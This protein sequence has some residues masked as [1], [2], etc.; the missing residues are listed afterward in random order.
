MKNE[1]RL[2]AYER[3]LA[4][5][6]PVR[7]AGARGLR[8]ELKLEL[9][10]E[11]GCSRDDQQLRLYPEHDSRHGRADDRVDQRGRST[12]QRHLR[13]RTRVPLL[14][15]VEDG[16][17]LLGQGEPGG[18]DPLLLLDPPVDEGNDRRLP[19]TARPR[20]HPLNGP[21]HR[22][23]LRPVPFAPLVVSAGFAS[24]APARPSRPRR[25][26]GASTATL[27]AVC[28]PIEP[29]TGSSRLGDGS[30][31]RAVV[32]LLVAGSGSPSNTNRPSTRRW[33]VRACEGRR[34]DL[35]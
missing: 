2:L 29:S 8:F 18:N 23:G 17:H 22:A 12:S 11:H 4:S 32:G 35:R 21:C 6:P 20:S 24:R 15:H 27:R 33:A 10:L 13:Q 1:E 3:L 19:V 34:E 25:T 30:S 7:R 16:R 31:V 14:G 26:A 5:R 9:D 28:S